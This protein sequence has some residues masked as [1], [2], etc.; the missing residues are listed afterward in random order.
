MAISRVKALTCCVIEPFTYERLTGIKSSKML[1]Y[2]LK[3]EDR[4]G[5]IA[6]ATFNKFHETTV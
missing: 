3:E 2:R 5:E 1:Q 6:Q 4:L